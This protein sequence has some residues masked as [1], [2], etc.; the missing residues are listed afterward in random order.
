MDASHSSDFVTKEDSLVLIPR[1]VS[2][3]DHLRASGD[4]MESL[5]VDMYIHLDDALGLDPELGIPPLFQVDHLLL[6][7]GFTRE[8]AWLLH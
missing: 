1:L 2:V 6:H 7:P 5:R 4:V 8:A 3:T